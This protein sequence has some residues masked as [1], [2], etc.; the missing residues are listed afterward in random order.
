MLLSI[1][2]VEMAHSRNWAKRMS[3]QADTSCLL[4]TTVGVSQ[5]AYLCGTPL[6]DDARLRDSSDSKYLA[7]DKKSAAD[8]NL[9][10]FSL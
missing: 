8:G 9:K 5:C 3:R 2:S 6:L 7:S 10:N 1:L 4:T